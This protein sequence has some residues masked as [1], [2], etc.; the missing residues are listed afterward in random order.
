VGTAGEVWATS[1]G[2]NWAETSVGFGCHAV[3]P[4]LA[5]DHMDAVYLFVAGGEDFRSQASVDGLGWATPASLTASVT[6]RYINDVLLVSNFAWAVGDAGVMCIGG[7]V[8]PSGELTS[9][10]LRGIAWGDNTAIVVGD[11][12]TIIRADVNQ[13]TFHWGAPIIQNSPTRLRLNGVCFNGVG[14]LAVGESG[15]VIASPSRKDR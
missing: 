13:A 5:S 1:D 7:R 12:G 14:Y 10:H 11:V 6:N 9:R 3:S 15:I 8:Y 2:V 4:N